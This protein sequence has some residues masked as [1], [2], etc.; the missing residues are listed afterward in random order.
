MI[1]DRRL[2]SVIGADQLLLGMVEVH[3]LAFPGFFLTE[4]GPNFLMRYYQTV[5][6][7]PDGLVEIKTSNGGV[8]GFAVGFLD[9]G[10][11]YAH[12]RSRRLSM[13]MPIF[14]AVIR[15]PRLLIKVIQNARKVNRAEYDE[16]T[17]ELS[18]IG[19]NPAFS[20]T[21]SE[22]LEAFVTRAKR[23]G[24]TKICLTTD[25]QDNLKANRF[26]LKHRFVL[27]GQ[28]DDNGRLMNCYRFDL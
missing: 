4:M 23:V 22:L 25:A 16:K 18:S 24:A 2:D 10:R 13:L 7:Y 27:E 26:Y 20:G 11:F 12:L 14:F 17:V 8:I 15:R 1:G 5:L 28:Y 9:P 19:I 21:G 6:S 3:T